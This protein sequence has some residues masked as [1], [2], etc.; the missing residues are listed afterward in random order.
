[1]GCREGCLVPPPQGC[2]WS[3]SSFLEPLNHP[4]CHLLHPRSSPQMS[5]FLPQ[6]EMRTEDEVP[7]TTSNSI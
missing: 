6:K 2:R 3:R 1:M 5:F 7:N 4:R